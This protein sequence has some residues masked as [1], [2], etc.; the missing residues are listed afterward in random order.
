M[1]KFQ[2]FRYW[3]E[4]KNTKMKGFTSINGKVFFFSPKTFELFPPQ[5]YLQPSLCLCKINTSFNF[6]LVFLGVG[7]YTCNLHAFFLII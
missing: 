7:A 2:A 5:T 3:F 6:G 1:V 4:K